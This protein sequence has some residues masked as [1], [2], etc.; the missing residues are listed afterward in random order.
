[1]E[2]LRAICFSH[3]HSSASTLIEKN[4]LWHRLLLT[5][6]A[7]VGLK[8]RDGKTKGRANNF[9]GPTNT[10]QNKS[11]SSTNNTRALCGKHFPASY[12]HKILWM[13]CLHCSCIGQIPI[14]MISTCSESSLTAF[15]R[16]WGIF[17]LI[18]IAEAAVPFQSQSR[19][20]QSENRGHSRH[21]TQEISKMV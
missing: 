16:K 2:N 15:C 14:A 1:M 18:V 3:T 6:R 11:F 13:R 12:L 4:L 10:S 19:G 7:F 17:R 20:I 21:E 5:S 8:A 9:S